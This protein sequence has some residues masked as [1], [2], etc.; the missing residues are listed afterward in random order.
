MEKTKKRSPQPFAGEIEKDIASVKDFLPADDILIY[1]FETEDKKACAAVYADGITDKELL[2][3]LVAKPLS[4]SPAPKTAQDARQLL[5]FPETKPAKDVQ[6]ACDEILAGNPLLLIDGIAEGTTLGTKKV[7]LRAIMEP[8]TSITVK[9]PREGFIEDVKT[10]MGLIRRRLKTPALRFETME[11]GRASKT[12][13]V[14]AYLE[15]IAQKE[16]VREIKDRIGAIDIDGVPDSS[17]IGKFLAKKP[18]SLFK[19]AGTTE[20]PDILCAKMLEGRVAVLSDGSPIALTLPYILAEDFQS[21]QDYF[22]SP[23]RATISR[24]LRTLAVIVSLFLPAYYVAAELFRLQLLPFGLLMTIS[25]SVQDLPLSPSLELFF[26]LIVLEILIEASVRMPKYVALALSVIGA[27]V[28]GDTAVKAGVVSSPAIIIVALS[29]ISA[30][31][32]PDL[33]GTLSV[34]RLAYVVVAGSIGTYG[35]LL[36][37]A[38][39]AYYLVSSDSYGAPLLAPFSP[40]IRRDLRDS[41]WKADI[42]SLDTRPAVLRVKNKTRLK[43][44]NKEKNG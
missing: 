2:G 28:L 12:A 18:Y 33:T 37:T 25:G 3:Q 5:Y 40:L 23:Y 11:V 8:Q 27:L 14:V 35:I 41:I 38:L 32:V 42:Y 19:Q 13:V 34:I 4:L 26:L 44:R 36:F 6:T 24:I 22:V 31:T 7:S 1:R 15:G 21:S 43:V 17:Y 20:K 10:N 16:M 30:Y 29:G 9:G 39:L